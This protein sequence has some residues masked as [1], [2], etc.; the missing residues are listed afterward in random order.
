[1]QYTKYSSITCDNIEHKSIKAD[2]P[3]KIA[4]NILIKKDKN[5]SIKKKRNFIKKQDNNLSSFLAKGKQAKKSEP[6]TQAKKSEQV[7]AAKEQQA[8]KG[9]Q[10]TQVNNLFSSKAIKE[11]KKE[12]KNE[13]KD[14]S[15]DDMIIPGFCDLSDDDDDNQANNLNLTD[16][17]KLKI[18]SNK[19]I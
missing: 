14:E 19:K 3:I 2:M 13:S 12:S 17:E 15:K 16:E 9:E 8:K 5:V 18:L 10:A 7:N 4:P 6:G 11:S 1:M